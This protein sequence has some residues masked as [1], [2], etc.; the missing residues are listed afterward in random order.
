[1][2]IARIVTMLTLALGLCAAAGAKE[3]EMGS[4]KAN[5]ALEPLRALSGNWEGQ[6]ADGKP[7]KTNYQVVS[8]G[9]CVME[10]LEPP[11]GG[12]MITMYHV[13]AGRLVMDHYC[14]VNNVP[15]MRA[16]RSAD[17][18]HLDFTFV[19]AANL[20]APGDMHMHG[21]QFTFEDP[22]HFTQEWTLRA[23]G[24][25]QPYVFRFARAK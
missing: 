5:P 10:T 18:K 19:S 7:V 6:A 25:D 12:T 23:K 21:L 3:M 22:D 15:H 11:D 16:A 9:S 14:S 1:M 4:A 20:T 17:P 24:K 13:D 8:G 2:R